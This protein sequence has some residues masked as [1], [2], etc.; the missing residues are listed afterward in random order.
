MSPGSYNRDVLNSVENKE[1]KIEGSRAGGKVGGDDSGKRIKTSN[2]DN[3]TSGIGCLGRLF[4]VFEKRKINCHQQT[5]NN[6]LETTTSNNK[7]YKINQMSVNTQNFVQLSDKNDS[8]SSR[9]NCDCVSENQLTILN[10]NEKMRP[11]SM[12]TPNKMKN[13]KFKNKNST[14]NNDN[15]SK[16]SD[17]NKNPSINRDKKEYGTNIIIKPPA[18]DKITCDNPR[19]SSIMKKFSSNSSIPGYSEM[20][21][22]D[23][24][25]EDDI[26][27]TIELIPR[28]PTAIRPDLEELITQLDEDALKLNQIIVENRDDGESEIYVKKSEPPRSF[29]PRSFETQRSRSAG[30]IFISSGDMTQI[31]ED[32]ELFNFGYGQVKV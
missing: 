18:I 6:S 29:R 26:V 8:N 16:I 9:I 30:V 24:D 23:D 7:S 28:R 4:L 11:K 1:Q 15:N 5:R 32:D 22:S 13:K 17:N 3:D 20:I 12:D 25:D 2:T 14:T 10:G 27:E 31:T 19:S 21:S